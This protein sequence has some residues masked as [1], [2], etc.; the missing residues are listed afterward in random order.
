MGSSQSTKNI[1]FKSSNKEKKLMSS[2]SSSP[3]TSS[4]SGWQRNDHRHYHHRYHH[5]PSNHVTTIADSNVTGHG[6]SVQ[7][8]DDDIDTKA[9]EY[10]KRIRKKFE[11]QCQMEEVDALNLNGGVQGVEEDKKPTAGWHFF[12]ATGG[13]SARRSLRWWLRPACNFIFLFFIFFIFLFKLYAPI[14]MLLQFSFYLLLFRQLLRT[15][16]T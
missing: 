8:A 7:A 6:H 2:S 14:V 1:R 13:D 11:S 4:S 9:E 12:L 10:I 5:Q 3:T 16:T 15:L